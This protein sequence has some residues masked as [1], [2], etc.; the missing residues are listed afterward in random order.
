MVE[1]TPAPLPSSAEAALR[2][3]AGWMVLH[4]LAKRW[5]IKTLKMLHTLLQTSRITAAGRSRRED[6][7]QPSLQAQL[8]GDQSM[9]SVHSLMTTLIAHV[10]F[11][12]R[13]NRTHTWGNAPHCLLGCLSSHGAGARS[14][15]AELL[16]GFYSES[17]GQCCQ[18]SGTCRGRVRYCE[19]TTQILTPH[20]STFLPWTMPFRGSDCASEN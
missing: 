10:L 7:P 4:S 3:E 5:E 14:R 20:P 11:S 13:A 1:R 15:T 16:T 9:G 8:P 17:P 12:Q 2:I 18:R 19:A 6:P